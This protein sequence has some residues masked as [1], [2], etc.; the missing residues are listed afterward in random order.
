MLSMFTPDDIKTLRARLGLTLEEFGRECGV[1][2]STVSYWES[3]DRHPR[4]AAILKLN[5]L[6]MRAKRARPK[7]KVT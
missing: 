1:T 5:D 4:Y 6:A 7:E 3:G 2:K